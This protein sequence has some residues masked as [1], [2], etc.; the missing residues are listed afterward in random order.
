LKRFVFENRGIVIDLESGYQSL[1][2]QQKIYDE[3]TVLY[4]ADY[5]A[6]YVALPYTSEHNIGLACDYVVKK[7]GAYIENGP[8]YE[9]LEESIFVNSVAHHSS[10]IFI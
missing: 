9:F 8:D 5:T 7:D 1:Q 4:G 10:Y 2:T 3:F 6:K